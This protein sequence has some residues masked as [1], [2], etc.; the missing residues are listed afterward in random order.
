ML[1]IATTP[2]FRCNRVSWHPGGTE[3]VALFVTRNQGGAS[4]DSDGV[5]LSRPIH[6]L[7]LNTLWY[8]GSKVKRWSVS[9]L[10]DASWYSRAVSRVG[11]EGGF[12][13]WRKL[14]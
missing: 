2:C 1:A 8:S 7:S 11:L 4:A 6:Y 14:A 3:T 12:I 9:N 10:S 5:N 13:L